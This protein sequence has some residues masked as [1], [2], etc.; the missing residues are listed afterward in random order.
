MSVGIISEDLGDVP[1]V[2]SPAL[3][4]PKEWMAVGRIG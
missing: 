4:G 1:A 2:M 3:L